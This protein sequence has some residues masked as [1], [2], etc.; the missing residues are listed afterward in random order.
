MMPRRV[1]TNGLIATAVAGLALFAV[2]RVEV[3]APERYYVHCRTAV[4]QADIVLVG[5]SVLQRGVDEER[6]GEQLDSSVLKFYQ[7][8]AASAWFYLAIKN[9]VVSAP[10]RPKLLVVFFRDTVLTQPTY[11]VEGGYRRRLNRIST[12]NE[13]VLNRLAYRRKWERVFVALRT[14]VP[15]YGR[16]SEVRERI[17]HGVER[18]VTV[19]LLGQDR[20]LFSRYA[21]DVF[22]EDRLDEALYEQAVAASEAAAEGPD[23]FDFHAR[24]EESFLPHI[25]H[26]ARAAGIKL[27]FMRMQRAPGA[28]DDKLAGYLASLRVYLREQDVELLDFAQLGRL[29]EEHFTQSDHLGEEGRKI[30][31]DWLAEAL[32]PHL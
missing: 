10:A 25:I 22:D 16:R 12:F 15:L 7:G 20:N 13:P 23:E 8:G 2:P 24:L 32:R 4:A 14:G 31:T 19:G 29:E 26:E 6:L 9:S 18:F 30:V 11:R 1:Y 17:E 21:D 5:N 28:S 3:N 27:A